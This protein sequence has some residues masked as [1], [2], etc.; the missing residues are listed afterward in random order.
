MLSV[1]RTNAWVA[2]ETLRRSKDVSLTL[3][4]LLSLAHWGIRVHEVDPL[5]VI[6]VEVSLVPAFTLGVLFADL[7][8][9]RVVR[10][11]GERTD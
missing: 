6:L 10:G 7:V 8:V 11:F 1:A 4:G 9:G 2:L 5:L 3:N